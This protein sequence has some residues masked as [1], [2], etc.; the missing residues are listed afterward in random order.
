MAFILNFPEELIA[1][2]LSTW[3]TIRDVA[4]L[5]SA[6]CS[7]AGRGEFLKVT[8]ESKTVLQ[9]P[10]N[11][12][13]KSSECNSMNSWVLKKCVRLP[14]IYATPVF[15]NSH[16][17]RREY[18]KRN[19]ANIRWV[20]YPTV[21]GYDKLL[22]QEVRTPSTT[23][24]AQHCPNLVKFC[25]CNSFD[26]T[27]L[28]SIVRS[29]PLLEEFYECGKGCTPDVLLLLAEHCR[30]LRRVEISG[31][32]LSQDC[33]IPLV[34]SNPGLQMFRSN[35]FG[36]AD[37]VLKELAV[38]CRGLTELY[39]EN[40]LM[41]LSSVQSLLEWCTSMQDLCLNRCAV[42]SQIHTPPSAAYG[43]MRQ[44]SLGDTQ[45]DDA[46]LDSLLRACP[47]LTR[48]DIWDCN[49]LLNLTTLPVGRYCPALEYLVVECESSA[50]GNSAL[51]EL[52]QFCPRLSILKVHR[53]SDATPAAFSA[54]TQG[55][56]LEILNLSHC[57]GINDDCLVVI[58]LGC[59]KLRIL[60]VTDAD[61]TDV[62]V[63]ALMD[64]CP[65][66]TQLSLFQGCANVSAEMRQVISN[67]YP[68]VMT[69]VL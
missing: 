38:G 64:G 27:A 67:R 10:P 22:T 12:N 54:L 65:T 60:V 7:S 69:V 6:F 48:L 43:S 45:I 30:K 57:S 2:Q 56:P 11:V 52:G 1:L 18:L 40:A 29:C 37:R 13:I 47:G 3:L 58:A 63:S 26:L 17:L 46:G 39:L 4:R 19:G 49:N 28:E 34:R 35:A 42:V 24:I 33:Q 50:L 16:D 20:E 23:D 5:D 15:V 14:G 36:K 8:Y 9:Y 53:C 68:Y 25:G 32:Y 66:L 41:L 62:G 59:H 61:I 44:L 21:S 51:L 55:C 31:Q